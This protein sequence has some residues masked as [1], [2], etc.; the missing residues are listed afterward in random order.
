[1]V[2]VQFIHILNISFIGG[3]IL[4]YKIKDFRQMVSS[5]TS[6]YI[7]RRAAIIEKREI[8]LCGGNAVQVSSV[9]CDRID[10]SLKRWHSDNVCA[11]LT[12][13]ATNITVEQFQ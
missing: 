10:S 12:T 13:H 3:L 2:F 9:V 6:F 11:L 7:T 5:E 8:E 1:M 4:N